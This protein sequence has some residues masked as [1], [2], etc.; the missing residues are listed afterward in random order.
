MNKVIFEITTMDS[1][2]CTCSDYVKSQ[3]DNTTTLPQFC[4]SKVKKDWS[5]PV[6]RIVHL[7]FV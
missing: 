4:S 7:G 5:S 3:I 1:T 2:T 6:F